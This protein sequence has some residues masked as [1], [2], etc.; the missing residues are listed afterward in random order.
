MSEDTLSKG[1]V[2]VCWS[3]P[4]GSRLVLWGFNQRQGWMMHDSPPLRRGDTGLITQIGTCDTLRHVSL[5][6]SSFGETPD[7]GLH[8]HGRIVCVC[9]H[10]TVA[11]DLPTSICGSVRT[12]RAAFVGCRPLFG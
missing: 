1:T 5:L 12:D 6:Q 7:L 8:G 3:S 9:M 10:T 2:S 4:R 11:G